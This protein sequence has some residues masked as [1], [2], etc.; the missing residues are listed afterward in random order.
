MKDGHSNETP[1][2]RAVRHAGSQSNLAR[3]V[4]VSA[5]AVQQWV[6]SG[7]VSY[8]RAVAVSRATGVPLCELRPDLYPPE[9]AQ[10]ARKA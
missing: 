5:Q 4:G 3:R 2:Q 10:Q 7:R 6:D 8:K 1:I 9:H